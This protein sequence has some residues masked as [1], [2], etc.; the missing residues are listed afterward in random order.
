[1]GERETVHCRWCGAGIIAITAEII[2]Y[3]VIIVCLLCMT[4]VKATV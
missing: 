4:R 2:I 1:M 3:G